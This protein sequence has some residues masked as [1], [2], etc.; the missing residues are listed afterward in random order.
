[1]ELKSAES[2]NDKVVVQV[3]TLLSVI[4][5]NQLTCYDGLEDSESSIAN[6]LSKPLNNAT[7]LY[8]VSLGLVTHALDRN[9]KRNKWKKKG[10]KVDFRR[11][12]TRSV[13]GL[14]VSSR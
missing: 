9:L 11:W 5:T 12:C 7:Q 4:V 3:Q 2:L 1:M 13:N 6:V 14:K 8:S 10:L